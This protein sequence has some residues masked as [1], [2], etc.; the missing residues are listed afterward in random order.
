MIV[1]EWVGPCC[2]RGKRLLLA[3]RGW[4]RVSSGMMGKQ[5]KHTGTRDGVEGT[6]GA[7]PLIKGPLCSGFITDRDISYGE[8][9]NTGDNENEYVWMTR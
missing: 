9:E 1:A 8:A 7:T 5:R 3:G 6:E 4:K 2:N